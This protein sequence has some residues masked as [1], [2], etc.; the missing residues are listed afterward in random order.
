M[1]LPALDLLESG[2]FKF[3]ENDKNISP[4]SKQA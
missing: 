2:H 3:T 4:F 1:F